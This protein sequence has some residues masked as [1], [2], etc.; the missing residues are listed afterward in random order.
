MNKK[1]L[2]S[3]IT[4]FT[5]AAIFGGMT[6]AQWTAETEVEGS[7]IM[8]GTADLEVKAPHHNTW[9]T[10]PGNFLGTGNIY[11]GWSITHDVDIRNSSSADI[12]MAITAGL[13]FDSGGDLDGL[14]NVLEMKIYNDEQ[15]VETAS[16]TLR[17]WRE[18]SEYVGALGKGEVGEWKVKFSFPSDGDQNNLQDAKIEDFDLVFDGVQVIKVTNV[19][20]NRIYS[21]IQGAINAGNTHEGDTIIVPAGTYEENVVVDKDGIT[22]ISIGGP[23]ATTIKAEGGGDEGVVGIKADDIT[24]KG[25]TIDALNP[26]L[27]QDY[28]DDRAVRVKDDTHNTTI[29]DNVFVNSFRGIQ[30]N[31]TGGYIGSA[32]IKNNVFNTAFGVAGTENWEGLH[33]IGNT[34]N[35]PDEGI[36]LG[37]GVELLNE[38]GNPMDW[39]VGW[40]EDNNTF[41]DAGVE[42]YR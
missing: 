27:S 40:L 15:G 31:W 18:E 2:L 30:G 26:S 7:T 5:V 38:H 20:N 4:I 12:A 1:I 6:W 17:D 34:F 29:E 36:G 25:F 33:I 19:R 35:T 9:G 16:K 28:R 21:T 14:R 22:L 42:D 39:G 23:I 3:L 37:K 11:P 32:D 10:Y 24:L 13:R 41:N 8:T